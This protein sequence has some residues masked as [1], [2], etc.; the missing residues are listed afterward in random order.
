MNKSL[1][2]IVQNTRNMIVADINKTINATGVPP[3]LLDLILTSILA[4]IREQKTA[5]IVV[6]YERTLSAAAAEVEA[7]TNEK[8]NTKEEEENDHET[9][10]SDIE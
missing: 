6:D 8:N 5:E 7:L 10:D 1:N 9:S 3:Y 2:V 4:D